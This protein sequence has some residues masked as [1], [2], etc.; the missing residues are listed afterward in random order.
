MATERRSC[1]NSHGLTLAT[2]VEHMFGHKV[3]QC[4]G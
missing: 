3:V 4:L 2:V 1:S